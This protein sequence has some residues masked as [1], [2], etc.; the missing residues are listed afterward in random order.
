MQKLLAVSPFLASLI[1][2][3][4]L[5]VVAM[6]R[7]I[8]RHL[9]RRSGHVTPLN[10][11]TVAALFAVAGAVGYPLARYTSLSLPWVT[12]IAVA[13]GLLGAAGMFALVAGWAV[14]SAAQ[15][16]EDPRFLL[17][18]HFARVTRAIA[19]GVD[20][21]IEYEHDGVLH[22]ATARALD[23]KAIPDGAEVVIERVEDGVA[24]VELWS[25]IASELQLPA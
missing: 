14:P 22:R 21:E 5:G 15:D 12:L 9:E 1:L 6:I 23:G 19:P 8:D 11:P 25:T 17:Q 20:G 3:L 18:G 24:H 10:M 13:G 4:A 16:V 2:G 7:G